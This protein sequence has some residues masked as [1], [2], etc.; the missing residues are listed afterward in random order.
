[1]YFHKWSGL[2]SEFKGEAAQIRKIT[3]ILKDWAKETEINTHLLTN[4]IYNAEEIDVA[5]LLPNYIILCDLKTG[6]GII[7]GKEK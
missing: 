7:K 2:D 5:I 6:G 4:F 1:M 3:T